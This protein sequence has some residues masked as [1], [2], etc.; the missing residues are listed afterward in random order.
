MA[1]S[2]TYKDKQSSKLNKRKEKIMKKQYSCPAV[3]VMSVQAIFAICDPS[4]TQS[5]SEKEDGG[6]PGIDDL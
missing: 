3:D 1:W 6:V 2:I 4:Y 5:F